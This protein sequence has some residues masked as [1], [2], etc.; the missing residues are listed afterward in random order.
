VGHLISGVT[1]GLIA[2]FGIGSLNYIPSIEIVSWKWK[3]FWKQVLVGSVVGLIVGMALA[4]IYASTRH[5]TMPTVAPPWFFAACI[6]I[7]L[8]PTFGLIFGIVGGF[9]DR[10]D[11]SKATPNQ[12][13]K[14]SLRNSLA[15]FLLTL[16]IFEMLA[17]FS[18][19]LLAASLSSLSRS[20]PLNEV[21]QFKHEVVQQL[22]ETTSDDQKRWLT[23]IFEGEPIT[24][25][26]LVT[27][28]GLDLA[29]IIALIGALNRGGSA[30]IKHY[31]ASKADRI[32]SDR[33]LVP[34]RNS[35]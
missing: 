22:G 20:M 30:V 28:G 33:C 15:V 19:V 3:K 4:L 16:F 9:S 23:E 13:I 29:L 8:A 34:F 27:L 10:I 11:E 2:G 25:L 21:N 14:L 24:T 1:G 17:C 6:V 35:L 31:G 5:G 7:T 32:T 12:G 26:T 18:G